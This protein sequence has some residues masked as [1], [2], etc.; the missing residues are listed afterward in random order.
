MKSAIDIRPHVAEQ[1]AAG[2]PVV[3]LESTVIAHGLPH[4]RN[5]EVARELQEIVTAGGATPATIGLVAGR[6][7][8][9]LSDDE[10]GQFATADNVAK[11][12]RRDFGPVLA[13]G[14]LG[15]TTVAAT[16]F[17]AASAGIRVF[18]TGGIGG[19]HR[20]GEDSL[21]IS[22]DLAEL[23][24]TPVAVICAGAK[25]VL[26]LPR[27]LE[28]LESNGVPVLGYRT[29]EFPAFYTKSSGLTLEHRVGDAAAAAAVMHA[30]WD[31]GLP[32]GVL[33]AN[34]PPSETALD[35]G[36]VDGFIAQALAAASAAGIRGKDITPYL[37][38]DLAR[39]SEG[40]TLTANIALLI[41]NAR[42]A[43][44]IAVAY[45]APPR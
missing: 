45:S 30:H 40:K 6:V 8:I 37:L 22:A 3:A 15:A 5:I 28:V 43:T 35:S 10:I 32:S 29:G 17:T 39:R 31:L 34:P 7:V 23:A 1:L 2:N 20:G 16:M 11:V 38:A 4:P 14:G 36:Q 44:A 42:L 33:I 25:S 27:T 12:S 24:Q 19:V 18:A 21:D 41:S 26:D 13:G 9:G